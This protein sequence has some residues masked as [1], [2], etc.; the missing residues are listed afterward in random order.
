MYD[1]T[2]YP[3]ALWSRYSVFDGLAGMRV[4][5]ITQDRQ[6][7]IWIA[8]ADGGVSRF[9]GEHFDNLTVADG[10]PGT[11]VMSIAEGADGL[12]WF[13]TLKG[14]L[15]TYD[16][17]SF[18]PVPLDLPSQDL[19]RLRWVE[20]ELW[21]M[22]RGSFVRHDGH[23]VIETITTIDGRPTGMVYDACT[24]AEGTTWLATMDLGVVATDGRLMGVGGRDTWPWNLALDGTG[25][26]WVASKYTGTETYLH[27]YDPQ[28]GRVDKV[29]VEAVDEGRPVRHGVTSVRRDGVDRLWIA[30]RGVMAFDGTDWSRLQMPIPESTLSDTKLTFE[31]REGN[32][33]IG[34]WGGGLAFCDPQSIELFNEADGL[35]DIEVTH[36]SLDGTGCVWAATMSGLARVIEGGIE[37]VDPGP[38]SGMIMSMARDADG[39]ILAGTDNGQLLRWRD[40]A[41]A[42][43][44][45]PLNVDGTPEVRTICQDKRGR[46]WVGCHPAGVVS[47]EGE[48]TSLPEEL[49]W[50]QC[51]LADPEGGLW[52]GLLGAA[53]SL[54]RRT[55]D[56]VRR[57]EA[58]V[59]RGNHY[60][61]A[62]LLARNGD[63]WVGSGEGA[64]R[65]RQG[66]WRAFT[67]DDGMVG[68]TVLS[69]A[70]GQAGEIWIGTSGGG[71]VCCKQETVQVVR[72]GDEASQNI[73]EAVL[74]DT[75]GTIWCGTRA[76]LMRYRPGAMPP[77]AVIRRVVAG[78]R[79]H[80]PQ[81]I[82]IPE[83]AP[84]IRV[85]FH[86]IGFRAG[87]GQMRFRHRLLGD[88]RAD[89][90]TSFSAQRIARYQ[91]LSPGSYRFEVIAMDRDGLLSES[92]CVEIVVEPD[93]ERRRVE[94]L[95][96][97]LREPHG[98]HAFVGRSESL[99]R[100]LAQVALVAETDVSV[101]VLGETGTGKGLAAHS[102]HERSA[103]SQRPLIQVNCGA[104]PEGV[105]ESELF[106]YEKGAFT[107]AHT[108]RLGRFEL[109]H[110]GTL[111]LDEI[112]DLSLQSQR[113]LLH[114]LEDKHIHRL[115]GEVAVPVDVRVVAATNCDLDRAVEEGTF[116]QDLYFR[117]SE[118]VVQLP[119]LRERRQDIPLLAEYFLERAAQHLHRSQ[120][121]MDAAAMTALQTYG[122]PGNVRELEH[123]VQRAVL[124]C[125]DR[126]IRA[127]DILE[128]GPRQGTGQSVKE[129]LISL[130]A[131]EKAHIVRALES[132]NWVVYGVNG[133]A[134]ILQIHPE[135][136]RSRMRHHGLQRPASV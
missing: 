90:W 58:E 37:A 87:A 76:G 55:D 48:T 17:K 84:E 13:A 43:E 108:R 46:L 31:D 19:L 34:F 45:I 124:V 62:M 86:G 93:P 68:N 9:D 35:P 28:D 3:H 73:V 110:G 38:E 49:I 101:L 115:G 94:A 92:A 79:W 106:G 126:R 20:D 69:L 105:I 18:R 5:D 114:V 64:L 4:E 122:W 67:R 8:T 112:G 65:L 103:R 40:P 70:E 44:I 136:L 47:P 118:F 99:R 107:G 97:V 71:L 6:G 82:V 2:L 78:L 53:H 113:V 104:L 14:G 117:L 121:T 89:E 109:A 123:V 61:Q 96:Q 132:C 30:H 54:H 128:A 39:H 135:K 80:E 102:I 77:T 36:L 57:I 116:R 83:T 81:R 26:L 1:E 50:V 88:G 59:L 60:I 16:G 85:V 119:P 25:C 52:I 133:A 91:G 134:R 24:D 120:P 127:S 130:D 7:Y 51:L 72:L 131:L 22:G 100:C 23:R 129:G 27:R 21:I 11:S 125:R 111:F 74:A 15:A 12:L 32:L 98:W 56:G 29:V 41:Q 66:E 75:D 10:L 42:P 63:I 33:W 95:E